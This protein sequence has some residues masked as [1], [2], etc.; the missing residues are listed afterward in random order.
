MDDTVAALIVLIVITLISGVGILIACS[1][2]TDAVINK[3]EGTEQ[4]QERDSVAI[5]AINGRTMELEDKIRICDTR[6]VMI[7]QMLNSKEAEE[8]STKQEVGKMSYKVKPNKYER[9]ID[10]VFEHDGEEYS[11]KVVERDAR[12]AILDKFVKSESREAVDKFLRENDLWAETLDKLDPFLNEYY[13]EE[14]QRE[15][16]KW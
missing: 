9:T 11:F 6:L 3:I 4:R 12:Q 7:Q 14:F 15:V 1:F 13:E 5:T 8:K 2:M 10:F 16:R